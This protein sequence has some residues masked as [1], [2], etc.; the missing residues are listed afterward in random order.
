MEKNF[1]HT[2]FEEYLK[3]KADQYKMYPSD[4]VWKGI[5]RSLRSYRKWYWTG[6]ILLLSAIS[7]VSVTELISPSPASNTHKIQK[8]PAEVKP[9]VI[10]K[11]LDPFYEEFSSAPVT[12]F[13][14]TVTTDIMVNDS[15]SLTAALEIPVQILDIPTPIGKT[16]E[17]AALLIT[18]LE[19]LGKHEEYNIELSWPVTETASPAKN[20]FVKGQSLDISK[21]ESSTHINWLE[22]RIGIKLPTNIIKHISWQLAFAPTVN[23]RKLTSSDNIKNVRPQQVP[24]AGFDGNVNSVVNHRPALGF[25]LGTHALIPLNKRITLKGGI[26]FNYS[27]YDIEAFLSQ[28]QSATIALDATLFGSGPRTLTSYTNINNF[29]GASSENLKNQYFQLSVPVGLE[30]KVF[31]GQHV[32]FRIAGTLQPSYAL[33]RNTYML[34][35][36]YKNYTKEPTLVRRWNV[37]AGAE[38][39]LSYT[40]GAIRWQVGPQ[41]RYQLLSSYETEYPIKE[42][43]TEY[44]IK[45]GI[46]KTIR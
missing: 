27:K 20:A 37:N 46:T 12:S 23:Y 15:G 2:D 38:A 33:N 10:A 35:T 45:V 26:Q 19:P 24:I 25:E 6:F 18:G 9:A 14:E 22:D 3:E 44:G 13:K 34:T 4:K 31:G 41:F 29:S 1:Y 42:Y 30:Y 5:D 7:Y 36:D 16:P 32:Q 28:R 17:K 11:Q 39:F 43:L 8:A 21:V 40:R